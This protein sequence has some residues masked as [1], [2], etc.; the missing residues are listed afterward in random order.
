MQNADS[1]MLLIR[2]IPQ[3]RQLCVVDVPEI[4]T[5]R[6]IHYLKE[7]VS[8]VIFDPFCGGMFTYYFN[9]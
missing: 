5:G 1:P 8:K 4:I 6:N 3:T 9:N 7:V 2:G